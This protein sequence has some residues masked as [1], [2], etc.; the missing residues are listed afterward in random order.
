MFCLVRFA[1]NGQESAAIGSELGNDDAIK[2]A[3]LGGW[4]KGAAGASH[5]FDVL[6]RNWITRENLCLKFQGQPRDGG[7]WWLGIYLHRIHTC[8]KR[9][10]QRG[11]L[12]KILLGCVV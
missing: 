7:L 10:L 11:L 4:T 9:L 3:I 2:E 5:G 8:R 1:A 12:R 6:A